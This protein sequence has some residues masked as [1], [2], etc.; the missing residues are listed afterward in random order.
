MCQDSRISVAPT[1]LSLNTS[2]SVTGGQVIVSCRPPPLSG[3]EVP[4]VM[5]INRVLH[6]NSNAAAT[7][8]VTSQALVNGGAP[9]PVTMPGAVASGG[10]STGTLTLTMNQAKCKDGGMFYCDVSTQGST[11]GAKNYHNTANLTV[12]GKQCL[13]VVKIAFNVTY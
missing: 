5:T 8:L 2:T 12:Q 3:S 10:T 4:G 1:S 13:V 7:Q 11:Q 9:S 6:S